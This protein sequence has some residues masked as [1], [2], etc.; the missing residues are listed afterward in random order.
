M[1]YTFPI[2]NGLKQGDHYTIQFCSKIDYQ[3][4]QGN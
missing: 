3:E 4:D 1:F 2:D